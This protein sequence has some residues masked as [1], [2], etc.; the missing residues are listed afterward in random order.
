[1][2]TAL[3]EGHAVWLFKRFG[4]LEL[5]PKNY[6]NTHFYRIREEGGSGHLPPPPPP[7][8][9]LRTNDIKKKILYIMLK[10]SFGDSDL[11]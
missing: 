7:P 8:V 3:P 10:E 2:K 4:K 6:R 9:H 1:M 5:Q 11:V